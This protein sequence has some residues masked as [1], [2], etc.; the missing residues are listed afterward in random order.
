MERAVYRLVNGIAQDIRYVP[1]DYTLADDE[2]ERAV[3]ALPTQQA[4]S[5]PDAWAQANAPRRSIV[6]VLAE[7]VAAK[8]DAPDELKS[9]VAARDRA[10][11]VAAE[12]VKP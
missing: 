12:S 4:L 10:A 3:V 8:S 5:D 7:Y 9:Y 2:L 6:D 11:S 1:P